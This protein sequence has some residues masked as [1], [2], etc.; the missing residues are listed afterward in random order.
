MKI[1]ELLE[2]AVKKM[3]RYQIEDAYRKARIL[4]MNRL[5]IQKEQLFSYLDK[6][7]TSD[8]IQWYENAVDMLCFGKPIQYMINEQEFMK[9]KFYVDE[10]VL[11]PQP[12]T[13]TLV[14]EAILCLQGKQKVLDLCTGSGAIAVSIAKYTKA[15]V[16]ASDISRNALE[17]AKKNAKNNEVDVC[18]VLSDLF[19]NIQGKFDMIISNPPYIKT[20]VIPT[21]SKEVQ[22]EP[23][24]ALDGGTDG[25]VFYKKIAKEADLY[26]V[27]NGYL[28]LEI[29]Y[30]QKDR[31]IELFQQTNKYDKIE[32]IQDLEGNDRVIKMKKKG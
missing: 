19:E 25:L 14:E 8:Q 20:N 32:C 6:E 17:I 4:L 16:T 12:D 11:I 21:L 29:G 10:S 7:A 31:V 27:S 13:E 2:N 1:K 9:M 28:L 30:D 23:H 18:Y 26:L 24:L 15:Q 22:K 3:E 5:K